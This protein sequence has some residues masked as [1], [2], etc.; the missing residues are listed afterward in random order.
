MA[1]QDA[2]R[3]PRATSRHP[4]GAYRAHDLEPLIRGLAH[5]WVNLEGLAVL[6]H[7]V[8]RLSEAISQAILQRYSIPRL[9]PFDSLRR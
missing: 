1:Q 4:K 5:K 2:L 3:A 6:P 7:Q 9:D 8:H